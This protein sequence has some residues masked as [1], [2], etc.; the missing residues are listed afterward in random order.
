MPIN[1]QQLNKALKSQT[2]ELATKYSDFFENLKKSM[3]EIVTETSE[4]QIQIL[5]R[6][7]EMIDSLTRTVTKVKE[8]IE[9]H[10]TEISDTQEILCHQKKAIESLKR[11]FETAEIRARS[12][13]LIFHGIKEETGETRHA[14][15]RKICELVNMHYGMAGASIDFPS[16]LGAPPKSPRGLPLGGKL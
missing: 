13:N 5:E 9:K 15:K 2:E 11:K 14:L 7:M 12:K 4:R 10:E 16:R 6:Q 3:G 1:D 8:Q